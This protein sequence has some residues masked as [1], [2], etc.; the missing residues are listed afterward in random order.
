MESGRREDCAERKEMQM[1]VD[2]RTA[3]EINDEIRLLN[4]YLDRLHD[5][6][7]NGT[8]TTKKHELKCHEICRRCDELKR[9]MKGETE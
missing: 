2:Y 7:F 8:I 6:V 9:I 1:T 3:T 4:A 5:Q